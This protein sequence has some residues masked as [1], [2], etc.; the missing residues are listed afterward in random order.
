MEQRVLK[1]PKSWQFLISSMVIVCAQVALAA[2]NE[3][4]GINLS[5]L[6]ES[7][8][9]HA[10]GEIMV[11]FANTAAHTPVG[12]VITGPR[13][14][15]SIR[16]IMSDFVI[17]GA[18]VR[19]EFDGVVP[20]LA[21]VKLP[22]GVSVIDAVIKFNNS[23]SVIYAEPNHKI[24]MHV[25][26]NDPLFANQWALDNTGQTGGLPDAD[27]DAPEGWDITTGS[28]DIIV[29]VT[30]TGIDV[31]HP[32]IFDN[33]W[34]NDGEV[35]EPGVVDP[36][37]DAND[38][39]DDG[40]GYNDDFYGYDFVDDDSDPADENWHG[41]HVAGI[42]GAI[43]NNA[44]GIAGVCWNVKLMA[45]RI[46]DADGNGD[47]ADAVEAIQYAVANGASVINASWGGAEYDQSLFDAIE[48]AGDSGVIFVTSAGNESANNDSYFFAYPA[49]FELDSVISVMSTDHFDEMS[50]FSN[51]GPTT[52]HLGAPGENIIST[53]PVELTDAMEADGVPTGY[54]YASGT[55]AAAPHVSGACALM[56]VVN[57]NYTPLEMRT[58]IMRA[59]DPVLPGLCISGGRLNLYNTILIARPGRVLLISRRTAYSFETIQEAINAAGDGDTV[60]AHYNNW[61][62]ERIN[63]LG[64]QITV[65]SGDIDASPFYGVPSQQNTYISGIL[66]PGTIVG[67]SGGEDEQC[68][69]QGFT[70][71]DGTE[72]IHLSGSLPAIS[73][74]VITQNQGSGIFCINSAPSISDTTINDNTTAGN[75]GGVYCDSN[76]APSLDK[77]IVS[78]NIASQHGGGIYCESGTEPNLSDTIISMN[79]SG[80]SGGG[81]YCGEGSNPYITSCRI[82]DNSAQWEGGG[83]YCVE[84]SPDITDCTITGNATDWD[85]A[86]IYCDVGAEPNIT[87][88]EIVSNI[89]DYDGGGIYC[90]ATSPLIKNCLLVTNTV[91]SWDGGGIYCSDASPAIVNCTFV[92]NTGNPFDGLGGALYCAG[93]SDPTVT[94]CIFNDN[95]DVAIYEG[96]SVSNPDVTFCLFYYNRQGDYYDNDTQAIYN[97]N[98]TDPANPLS[99][100]NNIIGNPM[101]VSGRIGDY[102]LSQ[103]DAGQILDVNGEIVDPNVNPQDAT[104]PAVDAGSASA[105]AI[106]MHIYSTRTDNF[107][108]PNGYKDFGLVDI[109][110]H[111]ND[112]EPTR[113]FSLVTAVDPAGAGLISPD[114]AGSPHTYSQYT[115]VPLRASP[116]DPNTNQFKAWQG[117]DDDTRVDR[118]SGGA[119]A[120]VQTNIVTMDSSK[121]VT[122]QFETI[123]V[124]LRARVVT[125]NGTVRPRTGQY[126]RGSVVELTA[127]PTNPAHRIK[128]VGTD[129]DYS[130]VRTNTVTMSPPFMID[131]RDGREF[132]E[133]EVTFY[134]ARTLDVPGD[135]MRIQDAIDDAN[136]GDV[137][138]IAPGTYSYEPGQHPNG[139]NIIID[140]NGIMLVSS[141]PDDP[142]VVADTVINGR[143]VIMGVDRSTI[144]DGLT[145]RNPVLVDWFMIDPIDDPETDAGEP[146]LPG[147]GYYGGGMALIGSASPTVR[148]CIFDGCYV[149]GA[150]GSN[151]LPGEPGG[152]G[153][154]SGW[155][156][157][158]G[159]SIGYSGNPLFVNCTFTDCWA[160]GSDAGNGGDGQNGF[161]GGR[162]G[163]WGEAYWIYSGYGGAVYCYP[164]SSPEFEHCTFT[165][166]QSYGGSCGI[167]GT[168]YYSSY[169]MNHYKLTNYG[170]AVY[171]AEESAP[172]FKDC[173][174]SGNG[175]DV[176][177]PD[178]HA[179]DGE[180]PIYYDPYLGYGGAVAFEDSASLTFENCSFNDNLASIGGAMWASWAEPSI[181]DSNFIANRALHGGG[182]YYVGGAINITNSDFTQNEALVDTSIVDP[183]EPD[184]FQQIWGEGGAIYCFDA[185]TTILDSYIAENSAGGS[186]GGIYIAGSNTG[187]IKNCLIVDNSALRD[188]GGI[189]C[190]WH[191]E[192]TIRNSTI[193][194][195]SVAGIA[196]TYGGGI[197]CSYGSY[198]QIIDS[199]IWDNASAYEG[200]QIAVGTGFEYDP[201][202]A[203]VEIS[204]SDIEPDPDPNELGPLALDLVFC[205]DSTG[206]M[207]DDIDAVKASATVITGSISDM[208]EDFRI[209]VVDYKDFNQPNLDPS[210]ETPY[211]GPTDYP[212]KD[213]SVFTTDVNEVIAA[214]DSIVASGGADGPES[215]L[216]ALMHC[217]DHNSVRAVIEPNFYGA[218]PNWRGPGAWRT[219]ERTV[220]A[221]IIMGDAPSHR[222]PYDPCEPFTGYVVDDIVTA[223]TEGPEGPIKIFSIVIGDWLETIED[224]T[225]LSQGTGGVMLTAADASEVVDAIM[226]AIELI[227][228]V[229]P[230]I[231]V[232]DTCEL[233]GLDIDTQ[234]WDLNSHNIGEDPLFTYGYY[235]SQIA[236]GEPNDSPCVNTGSA[237]VRDPNVD[238]DPN[239]YTTRTDGVGDFGIVDMGYHYAIDSMARLTVTFVDA[240]GMVLDPSLAHGYVDPN[241]RLYPIGSIVQLVA[242]PDPNY[243]VAFWTGTDDDLSKALTNTVT[244]TED[245]LII[246]Q[247]DPDIY[248]LTTIVRGDNGTIEPASG[249]QFAGVIELTAYPDSGYRVKQWIGA[250]NDP[251]WNSNTNTVTLD[252]DRTVI[253]EFERDITRNLRVP[254]QYGTIEDAVAAASYGGTNIIL[255]PGVHYVS[256]PEGIDFKHKAVTL[257]SEDPDDPAV[258]ATTIIDCRGTRYVP[259][260]AFHFHSGED[261][262]T[263]I[264]GLT[265][266]NG[267]IRGTMG[268]Q[269]R[270]GILTPQPYE[271]IPDQNPDPDSTPPRTER[272]RDAT[273][274]GYGGAILCENASSPTFRNCV[275]TD[276]IVTGGQGGNGAAGR[277]GQWQWQPVD[278]AVAEQQT[279]D[280]QWGGHGGA[281][282][283]T[284]YGGAIACLG[285]SCPVII[286][287]TIKGNI[288]RG[289]CGGDGGNGGSAYTEDGGQTFQ[290]LESSGGNGGEAHGRGLGGGIF[291]ED[292]S[293]PVIKDCTFKNNIAMTGTGGPGG[294]IGEGNARDA[295]IL[296]NVGSVGDVYPEPGIA[297]G[298]AYYVD[299][300]PNFI[301]CKFISNSAREVFPVYSGYYQGIYGQQKEVRLYTIGG[302]LYSGNGNTVKVNNCQFKANLGG[303]I[304]IES[305]GVVD[306]N[307]SL[308]ENNEMLDRRDRYGY[309]YHPSYS[310][311]FLDFL[312]YY[313]EFTR[314]EIDYVGGA[315]YVG[316]DCNGVNVKN[317]IFNGNY[318]LEDGGAIHG[319]SNINLTDCSFGG[320]QADSCGG[321]VDVY[322]DTNDPN[323]RKI[324]VMDVN[325]CTFTGNKATEG[326]TGW[327][328]AVHLQDFN[329]TFTDC[330]FVNNTAKNGAGLFIVGGDITLRRTVI[331]SNKAVG[332][333]GI[334]TKGYL[335]SFRYYP[336]YTIDDLSNIE[337]W[338]YDPN[339]LPKIDM[340]GG[341]DIGGGLVCADTQAT[342]EHCVLQ[343]NVAEGVNGSGGAINFSGGYVN[344]LVKN[345]LLTDNYATKEGGAVYCDF[346]A[347]P[348]FE[349]C[350]FSGNSAGKLGGA[351]FSD[352]TSD[353]T[354]IDSIIHDCNSVAVAEE[355]F[356]NASVE[357]CLFYSN[358][359]GDYGIY[360]T[361]TE[362]TDTLTAADIGVNNIE[363]DPLFVTGPLGDYYLGQVAAGQSA[364]SP[365]VDA[366]SGL[367]SDRS[368]STYTTRTDSSSDTD[369]VDIGYHYAD[370]S[371]IPQYTLTV[372]VA[373]GHGR[374]EPSSGTYY[375]GT[376]VTL[377]AQPE[378][379]WRVASWSGTSEDSST[380]LTNVVLMETDKHVAVAF[381]QTRTIVVGSDTD[382]TSIQRAIDDANDGDVV[383]VKTGVYYPTTIHPYRIWGV[384]MIEVGNKAITLTSTNPEDPK[385]VAATILDGYWFRIFNVGPEMIIDGF[386][387]RNAQ[388]DG[389]VT[390]NTSPE[391]DDG[392]YGESMYGGAMQI[393]NASPTV[394]NCVFENCSVTGGDGAPG[395][396]G[397]Q[398][399]SV[400]FDGGWG[401]K[402]YGGAV[403]CGYNSNP[404]F[405][406]CSFT[407]CFARGGNGG[408]GGDGNLGDKGGRGGGWEWADSQE[409]KYANSWWDGWEYGDK[410]NIAIDYDPYDAYL[411]PYYRYSG[412]GG[413]VYCENYTA[414]KFIDCSFTDNTTYGGVCGIGGIDAAGIQ[415]PDRNL[416]IENHGGAVYA[417]D[418]SNPEFV[419]CIFT[420]NLADTSNDFIATDG[421][422]STVQ[423]NDDPYISYGGAVSI[424]DDCSAKFVNCVF[425]DDQACI[426][427]GVY[428][429]NATATV[430]DCNFAENEAYHGAALYSVESTAI[431]TGSNFTSNIA[432]ADIAETNDPN[433]AVQIGNVLGQGGGYYCLSTVANIIDCFFAENEAGASG[434]AIYFA[435]SDQQTSFSPYVYNCLF[436]GNMASRDGGAV[437]SNWFAEPVISNS[438]IADNHATGAI[439]YGG[440]IY[441]GTDSNT[442]IIDSIIWGNT[443]IDGAQ[444]A[445]GT[446]FIEHGS[447]PSRLNISYS[448]IQPE[449]D[450]N[451][452][453]KPTKLDVVFCIDTTGSMADDI[454]AV[455][456][457][458]A[459]IISSIAQEYPDFRIAIVDY[460]DFNEAPYGDP[461]ID[462]PYNDVLPFE[463]DIA[464]VEAG[465][466]SL[467]IGSGADWEESVY[468]ALMHCIDGES[469]N[470]WRIGSDVS[471]AIILIG[472]AP[473]HEPEPI[474][475]YTLSGVIAAARTGAAPKKILAIPVESNVIT[476]S[477]FSRLG[478]GTAGAVIEAEDASDV[479]GAV[480]EAIDLIWRPPV[481]I[482]VETDCQLDWYD[483]VTDTWDPQSHNIALDP[484]FTAGYYLSQMASGQPITSPCVD[485][486]SADAN[487]PNIDLYMHTTRTDG[488]FDAG[489]VDMGYHYKK[490]LT[491]YRLVVTVAPDPSDGLEHGYVDPNLAVVYEGYGENVITITAYPDD[492]YKV[493]SWT[494][495]DDD[496]STKRTNTVTLT[497]DRNV[498]VEFEP[499]ATYNLTAVVIDRGDGPH[500]TIE[501]SAGSFY[502][503]VTISLTA[504]PDSGYKVKTWYGTDDDSSTESTNTVTIDGADVFVYVEFWLPVPSLI[505]VP[506]D[507]STIQNAVSAAMDGDTIVVDP[508][509]YYGGY[510]GYGLV[511]DKSVVITS[512]D[513]HDPCTVASTVIDGYVGMNEFRNL[514]VIFTYNTDAN[515]ILNGFTIENCGGSFGDGEDGDRD[516]GHPN[517]YDGECGFAAGIIIE[518]Y[519]SPVI[520]NCII[521]NNEV[522]GGDGGAGVGADENNN[523]GRGG[524]SGWA[525]GGGIY[526][527]VYSAPKFINCRIENN[528]A[529]GGIGGTGGDYADGG[530]SANYGGNYSRAQ[531]YNI[532]TEPNSTDSELVEGNLWEVWQ[533]DLAA[534]Y[535]PMYGEP[536]RTSYFGDYRWYSGYGGGVFCD[537]GSNVTFEHC[538][539]RGNRT[540]GG[541]SGQGGV[542]GPA[543][544][545]HEPLIPYQIPS[546]GAGVY[547]ADDS[548]I[549]FNGCTF[550]ENI[551]SEVEDPAEPE[552]RLDPYAGFGG[553]VCAES[554]AMLAFVDCNFVDND[555]DSGGGLYIHD[556]NATI[557]DCNIASNTALRGAGF[558]GAKG[559]M[560]MTN[561][562]L[563]RNIADTDV[564]DPNDDDIVTAGAGLYFWS[565]DATIADCNLNGNRAVGSGG[566]LYVRGR[567]EFSF[568][569]CLIINNEAGRDGGGASVNWYAN[570]LI[571]NCTFVG[572]AA[573]GI[574]GE[575]NKT[576]LG[577]ALNCAYNGWCEVTDSI[578]WNNQALKGSEISISSGFELDP[579]CGTISISYCDIKPSPNN[580]SVDEECTLNWG[581]GNIDEDPLFVSGMF[582]NYYL[583]QVDV[584]A[585]GQTR[586]S[587]CVDA[588]SDLA[589]NLGMTTSTTRTDRVPD[590]GQVDIGYHYPLLEPCKFCDLVRNGIITF[591]DFAEFASRWLRQDC[592][593]SNSW[594]TGADFTFDNNIDLMDLAFFADCWLISDTDPPIPNPSEWEEEPYVSSGSSVTMVAKTALDGWWDTEYIKYY[595]DCYSGNCHDSGWQDNP[596]YKDTQ[597]SSN[598]AEYGYRV[599]VRDGAGKTTKWSVV[600]YAGEKDTTPPAPAPY[601]ETIAADANDPYNSITMIATIAYDVSGV[602]YYFDCNNVDRPEGHDS[603]WQQSPA[604][605]DTDLNPDTEYCY[606]VR[607]RDRS[608]SANETA[609]SEYFCARTEEPPDTDP[610]EPNPMQFDPNGL[611]REFWGGGGPFDYYAEMTAVVATDESGFVEYEFQCIDD[612][613][614]SSDWQLGNTYTKLVGGAGRGYRFKVR[615]RDLY[616][617]RTGWSQAYPAQ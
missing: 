341:H 403:Y 110:Y 54:A 323:T 573:P 434:G 105:D 589:G 553:G 529:R 139:D 205:I 477:F 523:A 125:G 211:G 447:R 325:S 278:P 76:S 34:I 2:P 185:E 311:D 167:S 161:G 507:Y 51:Y 74:C 305:N 382:Y 388:R 95:N 421:T 380:S 347:T 169:P 301:N 584:G 536:R 165:D 235:L 566:G 140:R 364:N 176:V 458:S 587:P 371:S 519:A 192:L 49:N 430:I 351:I 398:Q 244:M 31:N 525:R 499:A 133:V 82:S 575:S 412:Y 450:P 248:E 209:A 116:V 97:L 354:V 44:E 151:G 503:G 115:Q 353:P 127:T 467:A 343:N 90:N 243:R 332:G 280:G 57:P 7:G 279:N 193:A 146:G 484:F 103:Y 182:V 609:W 440:G 475:G 78:E 551:A 171:A 124:T 554:S 299:A 569:N 446:G 108:D 152:N 40:N 84:S 69:L 483:D 58:I 20:G 203:T 405:E 509:R 417:C 363:G 180:I 579:L 138:I 349:N 352:W 552:H 129:N 493:K 546:Y 18:S 400:G 356:G 75:G 550:E 13:T 610:P 111:Y 602:E 257:T 213:N 232:D 366:G 196:A 530:G 370:H 442:V 435:G 22:E 511:I 17:T 532:S 251:F 79:T 317:S 212:Y 310:H 297:G 534:S 361:L 221:I 539:V 46:L 505:S 526:C 19:R 230:M 216:A 357:Y 247:F 392:F 328:G 535:W 163:S 9:T 309:Y 166:N 495:T 234:L 273:G 250:D 411:D 480:M 195:N 487:D 255:N 271:L 513:P 512:R 482:L 215:V 338:Y 462:Y 379:G 494:G 516:E 616:N 465:I 502:D 258:I 588:G 375:A 397:T 259:C 275:I 410:L 268:D 453:K 94:N 150:H 286:D 189:S 466:D 4:S 265:I 53:T 226:E 324:L 314:T 470:G 395:D 611:P 302:A 464:A 252:S 596:I 562:L 372:T 201:I 36:E 162:G 41:T 548:T 112:P 340:A 178:S 346:Y 197:Y 260:R 241:N 463:T 63:F 175:A 537:A 173:V 91:E 61:Y 73:Q 488:V 457:A 26:P 424:E 508:G 141:N 267:Y 541:M 428:W 202:P 104:S 227:M 77:C 416:K 387:I 605:T 597:L 290:G 365:A 225:A 476:V 292:G 474:T 439:G 188:G 38:V 468:A 32:D 130:T 10:P 15:R 518:P 582:G 469:L 160:R 521:R 194:D 438:T 564:S 432:L 520:K 362:L 27:I 143:F 307:D 489:I 485:A 409:E 24:R 422:P 335:D 12:P 515:T 456:A 531:A 321:A 67:F 414:P 153:G 224:F 555:A 603:G 52:V 218:D 327:G 137:I 5:Y 156:R 402:A 288:A 231:Y 100:R 560:S 433:F 282:Y 506:G 131:P 419:N 504:R 326:M 30:D 386:T 264:T 613:G 500:G 80:Q 449:Y 517:G 565:A 436:T 245:K 501:P 157:G 329:A 454:D 374:V 472:D 154:R 204:Y 383:I 198:A 445:V 220:R 254:S 65:R 377:T 367:A 524:W 8:V 471:R 184:I 253:V 574:I 339:G 443:A 81:I 399:H 591:E 102:Y 199:I 170:G 206:S 396:N 179:R 617:N 25:V 407:N 451:E 155:G 39:D 281:G 119:I 277:M 219:G 240:N 570:P 437:S 48:T 187:L 28:A 615:A 578:F 33:I 174:F 6:L 604:Y 568:V 86:G 342:I 47:V 16:T 164:E 183:N 527:G 393:L 571:A 29:A 1:R 319:K 418:I 274:V 394:R 11:R 186:G 270:Y 21:L 330:Y 249:P 572:N 55:S 117:T 89:A 37:V 600:R 72:G 149:W 85:G 544:R 425:S 134:E 114:A 492:G 168:P 580:I 3:F 567:S 284:G 358:S 128:W 159:V 389:L 181:T 318:A 70:I 87:N 510:E 378:M 304:Y 481:G 577:G 384:E 355:D 540:Y 287:C 191:N 42:I 43:G 559:L 263:V 266:R 348:R 207:Y 576:G 136:S 336:L 459:Q 594:C 404:T 593:R 413:A 558:L 228:R 233:A 50:G 120:Q 344:H 101:F 497:E 148:N 360:D 491:Q 106:G 498:V 239:K 533:W 601:I 612:P 312:F 514:G 313:P 229:P 223:A 122:A 66:D 598:D 423:N 427:G 478:E 88:C 296:A 350:T 93:D 308:F 599:R 99:G 126:P 556:S 549:T 490:G 381:E 210:I 563:T 62:L 96:S 448:D 390:V 295:P 45:L 109:G 118:T 59:T 608:S 23:Y 486:G 60:I 401:G 217:I 190:D 607:A 590:T 406:N 283:G 316:P 561:S 337:H 592:S 522:I 83:I 177:G 444:I 289:G 64:K 147:N 415:T 441:C 581:S 272:G 334:D 200:Q 496:S 586:Q 369:D 583:S 298:A 429:S 595:F 426:G 606:R 214:I 291:C 385:V 132:K 14:V 300:D 68:I 236:S 256:T 547:C 368:L 123:L 237:D 303:A 246:V 142:C 542:R 269:G 98:D 262:N 431:I 557:I 528:L 261:S 293:C 320:N 545:Q 71:T 345:C 376:L 543:G 391:A 538:E 331:N 420:G 461:D 276:C 373:D 306:V 56:I 121:L 285:R 238:I 208:I 455:K 614:L 144:I 35:N 294:A 452:V 242:H 585:P 92:G 158:G 172:V 408:D 359:D 135:Y 460:R 222:P 333:S 113:Q 315:L 107:E 473:P 479:P 322:Y 145:I